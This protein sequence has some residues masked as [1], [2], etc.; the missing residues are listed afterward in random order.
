MCTPP[1]FWCHSADS[2]RNQEDFRRSK[3]QI[4]DV[5]CDAEDDGARA[6]EEASP[7]EFEGLVVQCAVFADDVSA[8]EELER[9]ERVELG[10]IGTRSFLKLPNRPFASD[11]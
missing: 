5:H 3:W 2:V 4:H 10:K 11:S 7:G 9:T 6:A 8:G 1:V